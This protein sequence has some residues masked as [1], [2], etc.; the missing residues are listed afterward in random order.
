MTDLIENYVPDASALEQYTKAI[1]EVVS[2]TDSLDDIY[3]T[4]VCD[5]LLY[6]AAKLIVDHSYKEA[7][8]NLRAEWCEGQ[9]YELD[10]ALIKHRIETAKTRGKTT[11]SRK[12]PAR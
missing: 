1:R 5:Q 7:P 12:D 4:V 6:V 8:R 10:K 2:R 3:A 9:I 11:Y